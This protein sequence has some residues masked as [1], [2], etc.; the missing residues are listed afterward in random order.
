MRKNTTRSK[1]PARIVLSK[2]VLGAVRGGSDIT[3]GDDDQEGRVKYSNITLK[4]G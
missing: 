3:S 1:S 4:R 2:S